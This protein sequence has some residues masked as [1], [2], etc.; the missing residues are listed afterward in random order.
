AGPYR[1]DTTR[2]VGRAVATN[3]PPHGAFRGF[4]APQTTFAYERQMEKAARRLG[5][6]PFEMRRR[7]ML[8]SGDT[9]A[10]SQMLTTSVGSEQ[11]LEAVA[12]AAA[13]GRGPAR[14]DGAIR[15]GRGLAFYFH[16]A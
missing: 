3:H 13:A 16:G 12:G 2:V 5:I 9:T 10:T 11:V 8:R 4:G 7:N 15:R 14:G 1:C 6:E